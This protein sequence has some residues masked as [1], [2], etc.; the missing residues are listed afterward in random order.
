M[1]MGFVLPMGEDTRPGVPA[2]TPEIVALAQH[3]ETAGFDSIWTYDHLL[4]VEREGADPTGTWEGWT[5]L[6]AL[7]V[8]TTH[9]KLGTLVT[10]TGFR[11]PGLLAKMAHTVHDLSGGRLILGLGAGWHEPEYR[12]FGYPFDHRVD[13]FEEALTIITG[14]MR[15]GYSDFRGTYYTTTECPLLPATP[16]RA[17]PPILIGGRRP[18]M[19]GLTARHADAYN[20]AWHALPAPRFTADLAALSS[21]CDEAGRDI[22]EI[23]VTV[24]ML[25]KADDA[26]E[27]TFGVECTAEAVA[28]ALTAWAGTGTVA[29]VLLLVDPPTPERV[30]R[31][32]TGVDRWRTGG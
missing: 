16:G 21:A 13:R 11:A 9:V 29:E 7:A 14:L 6:A 20:T 18:R 4:I 19:M 30:A 26:A 1:R 12:A 15:D 27:D 8:A 32:I 23:D 25:I 5:L 22:A 10:C 2:T 3:L 28:A 24:G 31:V 17:A